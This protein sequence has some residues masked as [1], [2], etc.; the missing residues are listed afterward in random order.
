[1]DSIKSFTMLSPLYSTHS[2]RS[3]FF[4][5]SISN[6][7]DFSL[8]CSTDTADTDPVAKAGKELDRLLDMNIYDLGSRT[9]NSLLAFS[10]SIEHSVDNI[11]STLNK[12]PRPNFTGWVERNG[13]TATVKNGE[14]S[15]F[16]IP[17][18][19]YDV[20]KLGF[21]K[22]IS[23][24]ITESD[25]ISG[26]L[27]LLTLNKLAFKRNEYA[28][29][30]DF[31][32]TVAA[33]IRGTLT[34]A[35]IQTL[36]DIIEAIVCIYDED[37]K[38]MIT[39]IPCKENNGKIFLLRRGTTFYPFLRSYV[40]TSSFKVAHV[41]KPSEREELELVS[42]RYLKVYRKKTTS[43]EIGAEVELS[44]YITTEKQHALSA[45]LELRRVNNCIRVLP[46]RFI[47]EWAMHEHLTDLRM[48]F[49]I[50]RALPVR[51]ELNFMNETKKDNIAFIG[52]MA[53]S[54]SLVGSERL[55]FPL[56]LILSGI[57]AEEFEISVDPGSDL[58]P[59]TEDY[60]LRAIS[61]LVVVLGR[62]IDII[63]QT[64]TKTTCTR[65]YS[66][67]GPQTDAIKILA[68]CDN[69]FYCL[70][71][72]NGSWQDEVTKTTHSYM[73]MP[74]Y[75]IDFSSENPLAEIRSVRWSIRLVKDG[76]VIPDPFANPPVVGSDSIREGE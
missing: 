76:P 4:V 9:R 1:M 46:D 33:P 56:F 13:N 63:K 69:K 51:S 11:K 38:I 37:T 32:Q 50:S 39:Y 34:H 70:I 57:G 16:S 41:A 66:P 59:F 54:L 47:D 29:F 75:T 52:S 40:S 43:D 60:S 6:L 68:S 67:T 36:S 62:P 53:S 7:P 20:D 10:L 31:R 61:G 23:Y 58:F 49:Y 18:S 73:V 17:E 55:G 74:N 71:E 14:I 48:F 45:Y 25:R 44:N 35:V 5:T 42:A 22:A 21:F 12:L 19:H 8:F 24:A 2:S 3:L 27:R 30:I 64:T 72:K 28:D 15:K 65:V 26:I